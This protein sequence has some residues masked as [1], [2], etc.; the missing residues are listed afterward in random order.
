[1]SAKSLE[2]RI[3]RLMSNTAAE[4][5]EIIRTEIAAEMRKGSGRTAAQV[6]PGAAKPSIRRGRPPA[7]EETK[8]NRILKIVAAH[9]D[10]CTEQICEKSPFQPDVTKKALAIL[11]STKRVKTAGAN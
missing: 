9:P 8:V 6:R 4:L 2:I 7:V 10:L 1:M 5:A 3:R 11:R